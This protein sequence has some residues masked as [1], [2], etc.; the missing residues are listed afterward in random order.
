MKR[1][2]VR[3]FLDDQGKV[4]FEVDGV[5]AKH[6]RLKL[7]KGSGAQPI[8]FD[9]QDHSGRGLFFKQDD[10]IWVDEDGACPPTSGISSD[11]LEVTACG[12]NILSTV[13]QNS[14][15]ARVLRYQLN[16][17]AADGSGATCDPIIENGGGGTS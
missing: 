11:Q 6:A 4:H 7:D 16:F 2:K 17:L 9:L 12:P 1:V 10:P 3:A 8:D 5:K 14:G 15:R 13:N